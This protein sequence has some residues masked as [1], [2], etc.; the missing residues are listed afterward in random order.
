MQLF[1][2][3][4]LFVSLNGAKLRNVPGISNEKWYE[5]TGKTTWG[6]ADVY[7]KITGNFYRKF[8]DWTRLSRSNEPIRFKSLDSLIAMIAFSKNVNS[9]A[10]RVTDQLSEQK[11]F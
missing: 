9:K 8:R 7:R 5:E 2:A 1:L 11:Q 6:S 4:T 10:T 3:T